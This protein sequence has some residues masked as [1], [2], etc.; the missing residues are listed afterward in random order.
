MSPFKQDLVLDMVAGSLGCHD[1]VHVAAGY[2]GWP[3]DPSSVHFGGKADHCLGME[4]LHH[5]ARDSGAEEEGTLELAVDL[6]RKGKAAELTVGRGE[7]P[8]EDN[9][10]VA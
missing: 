7:L 10:K 2:A 9:G 3:A 5:C 6:I 1:V 4:D 8:D